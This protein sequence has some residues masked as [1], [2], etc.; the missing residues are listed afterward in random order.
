MNDL[1]EDVK[2]HLHNYTLFLLKAGYCDVDV[3][4]EPPTALDQYLEMERKRLTDKNIIN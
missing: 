3:I 4:S 2:Q 1:S